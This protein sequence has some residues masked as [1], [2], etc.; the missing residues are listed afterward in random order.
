M[1][2]I[3][4][5]DFIYEL[6]KSKKMTQK[7]LA[8]KL[9][10]TDK[11]VSK[12]ERGLSHPNTSILSP[13]AEVLGITVNELLNGEKDEA[14]SQNIDDVVYVISDN[15]AKSKKTMKNKRLKYSLILVLILVTI[16]LYIKLSPPNHKLST[17]IDTSTYIV[18]DEDFYLKNIADKLGINYDEA[19]E[20]N[21]NNSGKFLGQH[22]FESIDFINY[23]W[24]YTSN[25]Y[26]LNRDYHVDYDVYVKEYMVDGK[27]YIM[28]DQL[29]SFFETDSDYFWTE[30]SIYHDY[31]EP[32]MPWIVISGYYT[33]NS[34]VLINPDKGF[35]NVY[36]DRR[37]N[38][39]L[40]SEQLS[41][42]FEPSD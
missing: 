27:G 2:N 24:L 41:I 39:T 11:A 10:V 15:K 25:E 16:G 5:G 32:Q 8:E 29:M 1:E 28:D 7:Q 18:I 37:L 9:K 31:N 34:L 42:I 19:V 17:K 14:I 6:R 30:R 4:M 38:T 3:K 36:S 23:Y 13:L 22:S 21:E 26:N 12:W 40:E 20:L 35:C 33:Y